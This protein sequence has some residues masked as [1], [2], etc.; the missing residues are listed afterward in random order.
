MTTKRYNSKNKENEKHKKSLDGK[1]HCVP[2]DTFVL[3]C[4]VFNNYYSFIVII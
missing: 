2:L 1:T 3:Y 4:F